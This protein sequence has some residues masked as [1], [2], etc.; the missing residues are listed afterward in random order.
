MVNCLFCKESAE[1]SSF[2]FS[3]EH[4]DHWSG[5][6]SVWNLLPSGEGFVLLFLSI[7]CI[8]LYYNI[9]VKIITYKYDLLTIQR[10]RFG[11]EDLAIY[12][13]N[14]PWRLVGNSTKHYTLKLV[15]LS[16][17]VLDL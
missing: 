15:F 4:V 5:K 1:R 12:S 8:V 9:I 6:Q 7:I 16:Q 17:N 14:L 11:S 3:S 10:V 2:V 13:C